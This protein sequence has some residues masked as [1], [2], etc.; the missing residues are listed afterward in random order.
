MLIALLDTAFAAGRSAYTLGPAIGYPTET[1]PAAARVAD[2][3]GDGALYVVVAAAGG[4]GNANEVLVFPQLADGTL[5]EPVGFPFGGNAIVRALAAGDVD[6]D[7]A[8]D[9]VVSAWL[10]GTYLFFGTGF[11]RLDGPYTVDERESYDILAADLDADG[12][13]DLVTVS[14]EGVHAFARVDGARFD[15][16]LVGTPAATWELAHA[17]VTGD[18][19]R[20]VVGAGSSWTWMLVVYAGNADGSFAEEVVWTDGRA[21]L[22]GALAAADF[23]GDGAT[24]VVVA[25][26]GNSPVRLYVFPSGGGEPAGL[27]SYDL[28][29]S[30]DAG[31]LDGDGDADLVVGH[32]GWGAVT[33]HLQEE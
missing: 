19:A 14:G 30:V 4:D 7:G 26:S 12:D 29:T 15:E 10:G 5:G 31:D 32:D 20:D 21:S 25:G 28:P 3:T 1:R 23:D 6:G 8:T 11:G 18:G 33:V 2:V 22:A 27:E 24:D 9:V 16:R 17:D 13:D